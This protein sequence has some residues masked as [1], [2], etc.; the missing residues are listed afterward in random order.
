PGRDRVR[1]GE[2]QADAGQG[3][4]DRRKAGAGVAKGESLTPRRRE[5]EYLI[6]PGGDERVA[7][8]G[9]GEVVDV[10]GQLLLSKR[11]LR[12]HVIEEQKSLV[13]PAGGAEPGAVRS[14]REG[15]HQAVELVAR[16]L[17]GL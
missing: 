2:R 10:R 6:V 1:D 8:R 5:E 16:E 3:Q 15:F 13:R 4:A 7:G 14:P 17:G 9:R 11:L 12:G